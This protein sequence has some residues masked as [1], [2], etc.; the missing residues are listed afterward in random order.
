MAIKQILAAGGTRAAIGGGQ[1]A[2]SGQVIA[3]KKRDEIRILIEQ[4][5]GAPV[6]IRQRGICIRTSVAVQTRGISGGIDEAESVPFRNECVLVRGSDFYVVNVID[7]GIICA[8]SS[9]FQTAILPNGLEL[10]SGSKIRE[11]V[12]A[13]IVV[14]LILPDEGAE[15]ENA[16]RVDDTCPD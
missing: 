10:E 16:V 1:R 4:A 11:R 15:R 13:R 7:P 8:G 3:G 2:R 5:P 14:I 9:I 6:R 12:N